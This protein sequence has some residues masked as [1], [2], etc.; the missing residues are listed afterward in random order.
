MLQETNSGVD[1]QEVVALGEKAVAIAR[2]DHLRLELAYALHDLARPYTRVGQIQ[3]A[4]AALEESGQLWRELG[5][6]PM[7]ADNRATLASG[8][9]HL[10]RLD[11]ALN[12][13]T[14]ALQISQKISSYWGE[15]YSRNI[16]GPIYLDLGLIDQ[17]LDS[18][19]RANLAA[20]QAN[21]IGAQTFLLI[22]HGLAYAYLGDTARGMA[23]I[24]QSIARLT[25][26]QQTQMVFL[27]SLAKARIHLYDGDI[28]AA[29][30]IMGQPVPNLESIRTD[31]V[32]SDLFIT[33]E[34]LVGFAAGNYE[35]AI[36]HLDD[37]ITTAETIGLII[38]LLQLLLLKGNALSAL[39]RTA[40]ATAVLTK[41]RT[42]A[43][44]IGCKKQLWLILG[45]LAQLED[46]LG[47]ASAAQALR[48]EAQ[49][50]IGFIAG[51]ISDPDLRRSFLNLPAVT[52]ISKSFM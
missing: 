7:L 15:A 25:E 31:I 20:I 11:E 4:A 50:V 5:K 17:A 37:T 47:H 43:Q 38:P 30:K 48:Q 21:F 44:A 16:L 45:A 3:Q 6:M 27:P 10:G 26:M 42:T 29:A 39:N 22:D 33:V 13:A 35:Q 18:W 41:A 9:R 12:L 52:S 40:E 14:E 32:T 23:F 34:S 36:S 8:Y 51:Q 46:S 49:T 28:A 2:E 1:P 24:E 19:E